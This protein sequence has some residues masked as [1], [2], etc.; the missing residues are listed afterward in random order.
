M[1]RMRKSLKEDWT[2]LP[3]L[4]FLVTGFVVAI[5]DF[6]FLQN[7]IFQIYALAGLCLLLIGGYLRYKI[8]FELK[9]KA[10][11]S[12]LAS[13]TRLQIIESHQLITDGYYKHVR[14]PLYLSETLRN[15]GFVLIFSSIYGV[16]VIALGTIFL[17]LRI[18]I[19]EKMLI[20][21]FGEN[22]KEYQRNTKRII[23]YIY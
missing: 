15:F 18:R 9:E 2:L 21:E 12:S 19:E 1:L 7:L 6:I 22:Y 20:E 4:V 13:T 11:F 5:L 14:H 23:P 8:R 10:G 3:I 16:L 17:L